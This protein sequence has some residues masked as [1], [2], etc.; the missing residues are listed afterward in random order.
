M[1]LSAGS[2]I[3]VFDTTTD[4][5]NTSAAVNATTYSVVGD[6]TAF[7]NSDEAALFSAILECKFTTTQPAD[8]DTIT[9]YARPINI[10]TTNDAPVPSAEYRHTYIGDFPID[11]ATAAD[12]LMYLPLAGLKFPN[13]KA[14]TE[15]EFYIYN[16]TDQT[17]TSGWKLHI[18]PMGYNAV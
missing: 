9:L 11:D 2:A 10:L 4:V 5:S 16:N 3:E 12:T 1:A 18:T 7:T 14:N 13:V 6:I 8:D 17:I 15:F